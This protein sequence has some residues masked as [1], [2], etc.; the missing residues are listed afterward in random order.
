MHKSFWTPL[1]H[2]PHCEPMTPYLP[3]DF[4]HLEFESDPTKGRTMLRTRY[5]EEQIIGILTEH[6]PDAKCADLCCQ[7]AFKTDPGMWRRMRTAVTI[8][9]PPRLSEQVSQ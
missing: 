2:Y 1:R 3:R 8:R 5:S 9:M 4:F 6:E 7:S